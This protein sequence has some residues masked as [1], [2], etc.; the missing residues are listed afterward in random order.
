[1][2][3]GSYRRRD[4][5]RRNILSR[6]LA[7]WM[8]FLMV[9]S[10]GSMFFPARLSACDCADL[11]DLKNMLDLIDVYDREYAKSAKEADDHSS[12][13]GHSE[14]IFN[15]AEYDAQKAF[16]RNYTALVRNSNSTNSGFWSAATDTKKCTSRVVEGGTACLSPLLLKHE[17]VHVQ[18]C[19]KQ[20]A[21]LN[22]LWTTVYCMASGRC[23][24]RDTM[25]LAEAYREEVDAYK[26]QREETLKQM[27]LAR[28][29]LT[30]SPNRQYTCEQKLKAI[31]PNYKNYLK[32]VVG[33]A[34]NWLLP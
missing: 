15:T 31:D 33:A 14:I 6:F 5:T 9:L 18:A 23:E 16:S 8:A 12:I 7:S 25:T 17:D 28:Q 30:S 10:P 4:M 1:M 20:K 26:I 22:N 11:I 29:D 34:F 3:T 19:L 32:D 13:Q 27:E 21:F 24:Y 2:A